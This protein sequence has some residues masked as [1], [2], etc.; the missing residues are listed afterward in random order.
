MTAPAPIDFIILL[1]LKLTQQ[2]FPRIIL[3]QLAAAILLADTLAKL[4]IG[5]LESSI[6]TMDW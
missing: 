3:D 2:H 4:R 1:V 5:A 6:R